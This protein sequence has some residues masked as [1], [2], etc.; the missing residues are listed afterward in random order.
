MFHMHNSPMLKRLMLAAAWL[1]TQAF[2]SII[3]NNP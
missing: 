1:G 2:H 3:S